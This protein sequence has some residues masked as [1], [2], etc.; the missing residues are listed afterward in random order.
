MLYIV[1]TPIGNLGDITFR[2][3]E[4]LQSVS[5]IVAEDTRHSRTLLSHYHIDTPAIAYHEHNEAR[6]T[7]RLV[8]RMVQGESVAL[9]SDAGTP[10]LSDPGARLVQAAAAAG[11]PIVPVPGASALLAALVAS[12]IGTDSFSFVGFLPRRGGEREESLRR[13]ASS[14]VATVLYES[15]QRVLDTLDDL[16]RVGCGDREGAVC[17][18]L[19]KRYEEIRRGSVAALRS[20][21]GDNPR[22]EFVLIVAGGTPR[23]MTQDE[24]SELSAQLRSEGL[25]P[26]QMVERL[27]QEFSIPR[28]IAYK[29]AHERPD[30]VPDD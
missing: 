21:M 22:G 14:T 27:T 17:R 13:I 25:S 15:P 6:E 28:N 10:L 2:A 24:I 11:V 12:G 19:T 7:P 29:L 30:S 9:I 20:G 18:E 1:S 23:E 5:L 16:V 3:V 8:R 26:R 4:V